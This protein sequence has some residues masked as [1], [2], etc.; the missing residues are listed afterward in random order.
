[1]SPDIK[2]LIRP[3]TPQGLKGILRMRVCRLARR[4]GRP[5]RDRHSSELTSVGSLWFHDDSRAVCNMIK[6]ITEAAKPA[7]RP[8]TAAE[9]PKM[10][11]VLARLK[12]D[13]DGSSQSRRQLRPQKGADLKILQPKSSQQCM[14]AQDSDVFPEPTAPDAQ[15]WPFWI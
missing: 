10:F 11:T 13:R 4:W 9:C 5:P 2:G 14:N 7:G 15:T 6:V 1:M 8:G 3:G 12:D